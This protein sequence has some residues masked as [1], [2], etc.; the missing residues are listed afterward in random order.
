MHKKP[1]A[2]AWLTWKDRH[3]ANLSI[4][5]LGVDWANG[6][7]AVWW[8][9]EE[10]KRRMRGGDEKIVQVKVGNQ[11]LNSASQWTSVSESVGMD[12]V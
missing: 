5:V 7:C 9:G 2:C 8:W 4:S 3:L 11:I 12:S 10:R 1:A 6:V